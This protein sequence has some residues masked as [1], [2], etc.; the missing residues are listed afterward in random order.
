VRATQVSRWR[1]SA[2]GLR[3]VRRP[4][5]WNQPVGGFT[6]S[7]SPKCRA[8]L[9]RPRLR[10]DPPRPGDQPGFVGPAVAGLSSGA[11]TALGRAT[12][13]GVDIV[14]SGACRRRRPIGAS[15]AECHRIGVVSRPASEE[16]ATPLHRGEARRTSRRLGSRSGAG[17][18][19]VASSPS[20]R[21]PSI[22]WGARPLGASAKP[23]PEPG[24]ST[25][26]PRT[27]SSLL[28]GRV[29]PSS[30]RMRGCLQAGGSRGSQVAKD[31]TRARR[32]NEPK[33]LLRRADILRASSELLS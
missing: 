17:V 20:G 3:S 33:L 15:L 12:P 18:E 23:P 16:A 28:V 22:A 14:R 6:W 8:G 7:R 13:G 32:P 27:G 26:C 29:G 5:S 11:N 2:T 1:R 21:R 19:A 9:D 4:S 25:I 10:L 24:G 30:A 31:V